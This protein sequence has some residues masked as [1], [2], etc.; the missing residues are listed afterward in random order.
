MLIPRPSSSVW[1][2]RFKIQN[3]L[4]QSENSRKNGPLTMD[5]AVWTSMIT[6]LKEGD[7]IPRTIPASEVMTN[8]YFAK[9]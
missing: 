1:P 3:P 7:Q 5:P 6:F 4:Y 2:W 9:K 8:E